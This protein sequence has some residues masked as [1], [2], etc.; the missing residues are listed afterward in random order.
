MW[1]W[2]YCAKHEGWHLQGPN[3]GYKVLATGPT[4]ERAEVANALNA[5]E[6]VTQKWSGALPGEAEAA[7]ASLAHLREVINSIEADDLLTEA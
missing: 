6:H 1:S 2:D 7:D 4:E 5:M 3:G